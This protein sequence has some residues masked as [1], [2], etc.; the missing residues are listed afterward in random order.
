MEHSKEMKQALLFVGHDVS[1]DE[2]LRITT[3]INKIGG[4]TFSLYH[5][6]DGWTAQC[7]EVP[8][9]LAAGDN[10]HPL[11]DEVESGIRSS[12]L[13]AFGA[14]ER[15]QSPYFGYAVAGDAQ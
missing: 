1:D 12:V 6:D 4:L 5:D 9:I 15:V 7:N 14:K 2:K 13:A 10:P 3:E 11:A 8:G